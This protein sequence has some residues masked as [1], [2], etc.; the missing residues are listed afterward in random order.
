MFT[1]AGGRS[2]TVGVVPSCAADKVLV[3]VHTRSVATADWKTAAPI[4]LKDVE[5][6][7]NGFIGVVVAIGQGIKYR[8]I[9][10]GD[11]VAGI[12]NGDQSDTLDG[13]NQEYLT[14]QPGRLWPVSA[15]EA[16]ELGFVKP[17]TAPGGACTIV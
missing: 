13:A 7:G 5:L 9:K 1:A 15:A 12:T 11:T 6:N 4:Q 10:V 14:V 8:G 17:A 2:F 3:D 16:K